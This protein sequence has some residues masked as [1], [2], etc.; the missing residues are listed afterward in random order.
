MPSRLLKLRSVTVDLIFVTMGRPNQSCTVQ[1]MCGARS[2]AFQGWIRGAGHGVKNDTNFFGT[3]FYL[4]TVQNPQ[5]WMSRGKHRR[6]SK[7]HPHTGW[8]D[9]G[10]KEDGK[11]SHT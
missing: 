11:I 9:V 6:R 3:R 10:P 2:R 1:S 5:L 8:C 4:Q 7:Y